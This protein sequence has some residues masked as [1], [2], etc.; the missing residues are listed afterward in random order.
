MALPERAI[1]ASERLSMT[2]PSNPPSPGSGPA[3]EKA[4]AS[5]SQTLAPLCLV[6]DDDP[7]T[8]HFLSL[9]LH[10]LGIEAVE[11][12]DHSALNSVRLPRPPDLIFHNISTDSSDAINSLLLLAKRRYTG[13]VQ[14][15]SARG[16]AVLEHVKAIGAKYELNMLPI[17]KKP[18]RRNEIINVIQ[19]LKLGLPTPVATRVELDDAL[20]NNW[21]AF[22]YQPI[23]DLQKRNLVGVEAFVRAHHPQHG[24]ILPEGIM[25]DESE[26]SIS[27]LSEL[28]LSSALTMGNSLSK[29]GINLRISVNLPV[30]VLKTLPIDQ[31]INTHHPRGSKWPGLTIDVI[32]E[33]SIYNLDLIS[34]LAKELEPFNVKFALD[35]FGRGHTSFSRLQQLPFSEIK[36]DRCYTTNCG[37]GANAGLCKTIIN[38]AHN[39]GSIAIAVGIEKA[40]DAVAMQSMGCDYGQGYLFGQPMPEEQFIS[41]IGQRTNGKPV[42]R[43]KNKN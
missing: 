11:F 19:G 30:A 20:K 7:S 39:F 21:I 12:A 16:A 28:A 42:A 24:I 29:L 13:A 22:W 10:A 18:F 4:T 31:L 6:V 23:I 38:L 5:I 43:Q 25:N 14:L 26:S 40:S 37:S 15:T 2:T 3:T 36:I 9:I 17:L 35:N 32:E 41:L 27:K 8:R 33:E 34:N 1:V